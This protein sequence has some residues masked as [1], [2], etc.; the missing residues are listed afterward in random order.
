LESSLMMSLFFRA[1]G[2]SLL[3]IR[4]NTSVRFGVLDVVWSRKDMSA[5][6]CG[7]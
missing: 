5:A 1:F 7:Q 4:A 3:V 2:A 6:A